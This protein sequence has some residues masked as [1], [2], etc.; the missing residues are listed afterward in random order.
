M[1]GLR[2]A[3]EISHKVVGFDQAKQA[4]KKSA[5]VYL[6]QLLNKDRTDEFSFPKMQEPN[7]A[8]F[9]REFGGND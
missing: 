1:N 7:K 2:K 5:L 3:C 4:D 8:D 6:R 9:L